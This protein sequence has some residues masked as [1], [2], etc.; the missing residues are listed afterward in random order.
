MNSLGLDLIKNLNKKH[1]SINE[2]N[3]TII[4]NKEI[5]DTSN[6]IQKKSEIPIAENSI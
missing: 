3:N 1:V 2:D 6:E 5:I 4:P